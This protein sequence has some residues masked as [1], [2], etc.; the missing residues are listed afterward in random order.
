MRERE[1]KSEGALLAYLDNQSLPVRE[2]ELK[3][4]LYA[5][6]SQRAQSLPVRERE[7]KCSNCSNAG[8]NSKVAPCA[9]A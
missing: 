3:L 8:F 7:L 2:R 4:R 6:F 9:G 1:L 5:V